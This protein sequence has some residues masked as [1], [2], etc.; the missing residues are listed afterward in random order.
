[1]Y[2]SHT[3]VP[4]TI[5]R[6]ILLAIFFLSCVFPTACD[7]RSDAGPQRAL[8][9]LALVVGVNEYLSPQLGDLRG[10]VA[11]A[12]DMQHL[13]K[14]SFDFDDRGVL[15]LVDGKAT[16]HG[17][18]DAMSSHLIAGAERY[19]RATGDD[20]K[21][22]FYFAGHG[23]RR[24]DKSGD[25]TEDGA[26][27]FDETILPSNARTPGVAEISDDEI[28]ELLMELSRWTADITVIL[29]SCHSATGTRRPS[30]VR[31]A[32]PAETDGRCT[33]ENASEASG[34]SRA[35][36]FAPVV[37][38][39]AATEAN[40][41]AFE[42]ETPGG[43]RGVFTHQLTT[44]LRHPG[45]TGQPLSVLMARVRAE[46]TSRYPRQTPRWECRN[47]DAPLLGV[48][49]LSSRDYTT[50]TPPTDGMLVLNEGRVHGVTPGS[51]YNV[52]EATD[53]KFAR[54]LGSATVKRTTLTN[55]RVELDFDTSDSETYLATLRVLAQEPGVSA[56]VFIDDQIDQMFPDLAGLLG[57]NQDADESPKTPSLKRIGDAPLA[58][59]SAWL[60][61]DGRIEITARDG[62]TG[63][64]FSAASAHDVLGELTK[65]RR[66]IA[67]SDLDN[68]RSR[69]RLVFE[70]AMGAEAQTGELVAEVGDEIDLTIQNR[71]DRSID[72]VIV[73]LVSDGTIS[74]IYPSD[75]WS[76]RLDPGGSWSRSTKLYLPDGVERV[77]D[78]F[79]VI[80]ATAPFYAGSLRR[81]LTEQREARASIHPIEE[82]LGATRVSN[83]HSPKI[84]DKDDDWTTKSCVVRLSRYQTGEESP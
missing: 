84:E 39:L 60:L 26:A 43:P 64:V 81:D 82:A 54:P 51:I 42:S 68:S 4:Q 1:M 20:A 18:L 9:R 71:S 76:A 37:T 74:V 47:G 2:P 28:N 80:A 67:V 46:V 66:W 79:K 5:Y 56:S 45:A 31:W 13:L 35:S 83:R 48:E 52:F 29:D 12:R 55:S 62:E 10:S 25:E 22:V 59:L 24:P 17:I 69:L 63:S 21:V 61:S 40:D 34:K 32:A 50:I 6:C 36:T 49:A 57:S 73:N 53:A 19:R 75:A 15:L 23:S 78:I 65:W 16:R 38:L 30:G 72:F 8:G 11:D 77:T 70:I 41:Y 44:L 27:R 7:G 3:Y 58:D 33:G 14:T